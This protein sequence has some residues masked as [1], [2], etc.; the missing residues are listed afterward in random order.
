MSH[1]GLQA[2]RRCVRHRDDIQGL[3]GRRDFLHGEAEGCR[4]SL[5]GYAYVQVR[6]EIHY[7]GRVLDSGLL[8]L[9]PLGELF[10]QMLGGIDGKICPECK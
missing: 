9:R 7:A 4:L 5:Q 8:R 1:S 3:W 2:F 10:R 6:N